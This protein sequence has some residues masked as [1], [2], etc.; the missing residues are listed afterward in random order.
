MEENL[1]P[2]LNYFQSIFLLN[3]MKGFELE[4]CTNIERETLLDWL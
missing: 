4:T 1:P 3:E 2:P